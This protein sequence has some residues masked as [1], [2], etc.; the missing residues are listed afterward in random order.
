MEVVAPPSLHTKPAP[1]ASLTAVTVGLGI[2]TIIGSSVP[3]AG[4]LF[5]GLWIS[6]VV[7]A[8]V[9]VAVWMGMEVAEARGRGVLT[10]I[11]VVVVPPLGVWR[12]WHE[13]F[14][15][16]VLTPLARRLM[17]RFEVFFTCVLAVLFAI[18]VILHL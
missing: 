4:G 12:W 15:G 11:L 2:T 17:I 5:V 10:G 8:W 9:M 16:P 6:Y 13:R 1:W 7:V 3:D 18:S 14:T